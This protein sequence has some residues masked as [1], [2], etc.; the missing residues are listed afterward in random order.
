M[1]EGKSVIE[2]LRKKKSAAAKIPEIISELVDATDPDKIKDLLKK[3][4]ELGDKKN[5]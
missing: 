3:Y 2:N 4:S 1:I 5:G